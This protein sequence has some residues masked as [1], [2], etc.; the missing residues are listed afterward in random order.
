[1]VARRLYAKNR[2]LH[3]YK[4][5]VSRGVKSGLELAWEGVEISTRQ[6]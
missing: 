5:R 1:M 4:G 3:V 2:N 6:S